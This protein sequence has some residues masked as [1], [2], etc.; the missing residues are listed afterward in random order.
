[1]SF[2]SH[3]VYVGTERVCR[4]KV[5]VA[6]DPP[7]HR[8]ARAGRIARSVES[9]EVMMAGTSVPPADGAGKA[10]AAAGDT[11]PEPPKVKRSTRP[12][13][14]RVENLA[15]TSGVPARGEVL[16]PIIDRLLEPVRS[17]EDLE[18]TR[19]VLE[20]SH[21]ALVDEALAMN[22]ERERFNRQLREY[23]AAHGFTPVV[24]RPSRIEEVRAKGKNL[25]TELGKGARDKSH[26]ATSTVPKVVYSS[27]VKN[28]RAVAEVAKDLSCLSGEA[29]REQ[30][31]RLNQLLS[32]ATKQQEAFKEAN[33]GAGA[34]Q[35]VVSVG[36]AGARS[37]GQASSPHPSARRA[38]SVTS[39]RRD[40]QIQ[41]YDPA[42][43]GKQ[44]MVQKNAGQADKYVGSKKPGQSVPAGHEAGAAGVGRSNSA[45]RR[46]QQGAGGAAQQQGAAQPRYREDDGNSALARAGYQ[47]QDQPGQQT[48]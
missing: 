6:A 14:E 47:Q 42:V 1:M 27:P 11:P 36:G 35:Y 43:A 15:G 24:T 41:V 4:E 22:Q 44:V 23:E 28:L 2:G 46:Q 31:A 40:K 5:L 25:N 34:S 32:E 30:Q 12:P 8:L 39:G 19:E 16:L 9:A 18:Q 33:P 3:E 17:G 21:Q 7:S 37:R 26:T 13:L 45:A 48:D 29:L 10:A 38:G 20:G